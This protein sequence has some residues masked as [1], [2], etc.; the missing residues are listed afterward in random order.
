MH[1]NENV[2]YEYVRTARVLN[3]ENKEII[4]TIKCN[5]AF[6]YVL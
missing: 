4:V 3:N 5:V 1:V 2:L 6:N